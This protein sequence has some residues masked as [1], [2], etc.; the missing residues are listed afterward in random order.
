MDS[1]WKFTSSAVFAATVVTTI[2][3]GNMSPSTTAGQIFCVF[4]AL[5]GIPLNMVVL[6]RVGKYMLA[7]ERNACDFIQ[8]KTNHRVSALPIDSEMKLTRFMI[9]LLSYISGTALF[10]VM[11]MVVFKQQEGWSYSQAIYY[12]FISLSTIGFGD[13]V[14]GTRLN[15]YS[16]PD[17]YYPEWYSI[18]MASW[19]F[20]GLAWLA[21]VINH[22]SDILERLNTHLKHWWSPEEPSNA[23]P[24]DEVKE[25]PVDG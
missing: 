21:L 23:G 16:N 14:A 1:F 7:I 8:G 4:F 22:T 15:M 9:H 2:G 3:Y 25:P 20:F 6:N 5:F 13:Y 17:R 11:P 18:L 10:F 24:V 19:I 12:C